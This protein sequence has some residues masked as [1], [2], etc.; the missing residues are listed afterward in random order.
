MIT[1]PILKIIFYLSW[2]S[3]IFSLPPIYLKS[4]PPPPPAFSISSYLLWPPSVPK[5]CWQLPHLH[6]GSLVGHLTQGLCRILN[7]TLSSS[8]P[9]CGT[10]GCTPQFSKTQNCV[11]HFLENSLTWFPSVLTPSASI[12]ETEHLVEFPTLFSCRV[13]GHWISLCFQM[14][15]GFI[16]T[17]MSMLHFVRKVNLAFWPETTTT[18]TCNPPWCFFKFSLLSDNSTLLWVQ[19]IVSALK[20]AAFIFILR[21]QHI[22]DAW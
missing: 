21:T 8:S 22:A 1:Y 20:V 15:E 11:N 17:L 5:F 10:Q 12:S 2:F 16:L 14:C 13:F 6:P 7:Q 4:S 9:I 19:E 3:L 18:N